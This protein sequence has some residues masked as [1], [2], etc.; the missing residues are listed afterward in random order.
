MESRNSLSWRPD[1]YLFHPNVNRCIFS[2]SIYLYTHRNNEHFT[3]N[4]NIP[5]R[6]KRNTV[7]R[8]EWT[9]DGYSHTYERTVNNR[10]EQV[11][12]SRTRLQQA[13]RFTISSRAGLYWF[14]SDNSARGFPR[15][16]P[17]P[18]VLQLGQCNTTILLKPTQRMGE[19]CFPIRFSINV[20]FM[21]FPIQLLGTESSNLIAFFFICRSCVHFT[22]IRV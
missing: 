4:A 22:Y 19:I 11:G 21:Q 7:G 1:V 18:A 5:K 9:N 6:R 20:I 17:Q 16:L 8:L 13:L 10:D 2:V 12:V 14:S 15:I 3:C